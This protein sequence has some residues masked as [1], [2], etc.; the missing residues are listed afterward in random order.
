MEEQSHSNEWGPAFSLYLVSLDKRSQVYPKIRS[1][2]SCGRSLSEHSHNSLLIMGHNKA[3]KLKWLNCNQLFFMTLSAAISFFVSSQ[4]VI[5]FS[6][7]S[8]SPSPFSLI[9]WAA[10]HSHYILFSHGFLSETSN[11]QLEPEVYI[12]VWLGT[13]SQTSPLLLHMLLKTQ[14]GEERICGAHLSTLSG[15]LMTPSMIHHSYR[16]RVKMVPKFDSNDVKLLIYPFV[17]KVNIVFDQSF[18]RGCTGQRDERRREEKEKVIKRPKFL[19]FFFWCRDAILVIWW[20]RLCTT[21][22]WPIANE[23]FSGC[24]AARRA[25][26][27]LICTHW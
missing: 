1:A 6:T 20:S 18:S 13:C 21:G 2:S 16:G 19:S 5:N 25:A 3:G 12:N 7:D 17:N 14:R 23:L 10:L 22:L 15:L 8:I 11:H 4:L 26:G 9:S 24:N 27:Q